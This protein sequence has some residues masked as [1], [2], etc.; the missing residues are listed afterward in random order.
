[1]EFESEEKSPDFSNIFSLIE[2]DALSCT[3]P[4]I[5]V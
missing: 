4:L 5:F 1:M 2:P 3:S